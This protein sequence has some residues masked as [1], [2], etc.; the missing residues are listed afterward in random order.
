MK[1]RWFT[2]GL[3]LLAF[4]AVRVFA[5]TTISI[6][7]TTGSGN[8]IALGSFAGGATVQISVTGTGNLVDARYQT[9]PNGSLPVAATGAYAFANF[10]ASLPSV[11][12]FPASTNAFSD[13][14]AN[15]DFSSSGFGFAGPQ[16]NDTT[17]STAI[18]FGA[19]VGTFASSPARADWFILGYGG[20]FTVP[21]GGATF[22]VAVNDSF[23]GDNN[24]SYSLTFTAIPEPAS[25][26]FWLASFLC[27]I[28][29][30]FR[31][32]PRRVSP[33]T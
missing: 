15:W 22:F 2:A 10:G 8:K 17:D 12:G 14:G 23:S 33:M 26:A 29:I 4:T 6:P 30:V 19:V 7:L 13:G 1:S 25:V 16:T 32:R 18:R 21:G 31:S 11:N 5:Q 20:T 28:A 27:G 9:N 3:C 24:G